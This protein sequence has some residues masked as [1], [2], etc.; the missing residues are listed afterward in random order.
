MYRRKICKLWGV[1][2]DYGHESL[3]P[4]LFAGIEVSIRGELN[5][6]ILF[7][8]HPGCEVWLTLKHRNKL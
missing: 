1:K 8:R 4:D 6:S 5:D 3:H 7:P 2:L